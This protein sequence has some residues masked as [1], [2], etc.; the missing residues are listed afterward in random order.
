MSRRGRDLLLAGPLAAVLAVTALP[1]GSVW[2]QSAGSEGT[3][4][5]LPPRPLSSASGR[6]SPTTITRELDQGVAKLR[7]MLDSQTNGSPLGPE[8]TA[9]GIYDGYVHVRAAHALLTR[10]ILNVAE[11][12]K[13]RDP[14]L[15]LAFK[16]IKGA[17]YKILHA[18]QAAAKGNSARSIDLLT[19]AIP[20]LERAI[21]L[22]Q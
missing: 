5:P 7:K 12:T 9:K 1:P 14:L 19:G 17:R 15:D 22:I 2:A 4:N 8:A 6:L 18:R 10:R 3:I 11:K 13:S 20:E 21:A 16:E